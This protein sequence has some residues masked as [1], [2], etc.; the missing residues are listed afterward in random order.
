MYKNVGI[1]KITHCTTFIDFDA[2]H[3]WKTSSSSWSS[4]KVVVK[5]A[6]VKYI[7]VRTINGMYFYKLSCIA[8]ASNCNFTLGVLFISLSVP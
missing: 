5:V 2:V 8:I 1:K 7:V 4:T 3:E 6:K